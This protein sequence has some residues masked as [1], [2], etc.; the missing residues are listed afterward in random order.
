MIYEKIIKIG[1]IFF[2]MAAKM[3]A[4]NYNHVSRSA[5]LSYT[6]TNIVSIHIK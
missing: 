2:K 5:L 1:C 4:E 6:D 3:A